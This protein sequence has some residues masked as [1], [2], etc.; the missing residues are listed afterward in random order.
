MEADPETTLHEAGWAAAKRW[1][2][3]DLNNGTD[4]YSDFCAYLT[5]KLQGQEQAFGGV[6]PGLAQ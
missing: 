1:L 5:D 6:D 3:K 2:M 4:P